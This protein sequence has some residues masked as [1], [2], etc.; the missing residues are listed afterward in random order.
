MTWQH[1]CANAQPWATGQGLS[2]TVVPA[3]LPLPVHG[4]GYELEQRS[5]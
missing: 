1:I 3:R 2:L 4:T 5:G